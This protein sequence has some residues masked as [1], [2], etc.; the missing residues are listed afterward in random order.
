MIKTIRARF[1]KGV[2][3]PLERVEVPEG[4][5]FT[6]TI[7]IPSVSKKKSFLEALK[8]TAGGWKDLI[9]GEELKRNIYNDRLIATR[10]EVKL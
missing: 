6:V 3:E 8:I 2:F 9:D 10:P 7:D 5:E 4:K 1:S